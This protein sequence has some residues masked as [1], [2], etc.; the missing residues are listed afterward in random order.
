M[1]SSNLTVLASEK[2][3]LLSYPLVRGHTLPSNLGM[4]N[5]TKKYAWLQ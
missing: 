3:T 4:K 5:N 1:M 2:C